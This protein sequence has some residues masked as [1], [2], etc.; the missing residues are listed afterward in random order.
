MLG[1]MS[2]M[3]LNMILDPVLIFS[4]RMGFIGAGWATFAGQLTGAA[5][6]TFLSFKNGNIKI[7][8][9]SAVYKSVH[10]EHQVYK[11]VRK[12]IEIE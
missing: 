4:F 8:P 12:M 7:L 9:T 6:L 11:K 1:L 5:M 10:K 3:L 2:G